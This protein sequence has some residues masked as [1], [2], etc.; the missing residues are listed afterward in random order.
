MARV[1]S[2]LG[3]EKDLLKKKRWQKILSSWK[4]LDDVIFPRIKLCLKGQQV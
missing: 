4:Q 1:C 3:A 2:D